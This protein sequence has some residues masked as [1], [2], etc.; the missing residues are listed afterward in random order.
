MT[1][2]ME[3]AFVRTAGGGLARVRGAKT[4]A[5]CRSSVS[6]VRVSMTR[7]QVR[8][9]AKIA[10]M[11]EKVP[12]EQRHAVLALSEE[13]DMVDPLER[14][15]KVVCT[16][17]PST[18]S[19]QDLLRLA[20][21]GM[22]LVRLNMSHGDYKFHK[23]VLDNVRKINR[24]S[25]F[26]VGT[27]VDLGSLDMV[28]LGE[29]ADAP[30]LDKGDVFTLTVRHEAEYDQ[31]TSEVSYD[32][33][34]DVA[35]TGD[36]VMIDDS[37]EL[38]VTSKTNT[39]V[40]CETT[41]GGEVKSRAPLTVRGKS[42]GA[43]TGD[44]LESD[45]EF[46]VEEDVDYV[47]LAFV[48]DGAVVDKLRSELRSRG[49]EAAIIAKMESAAAL[50]NA[51]NIIQAA[52]AIMVARGDLGA[53]IPYE[54][55]PLW[56]ERLA[57]LSRALGKPVLISTHFLDSMVTYP[58]PTRAEITDIFE[59]VRQKAD[60]LVL[61][62]ET[63]SGRYPFKALNAMHSASCRM[64]GKSQEETEID[65]LPPLVTV[66]DRPFR[67][68]AVVAENISNTAS[69]LA[70]VR[71]AKAIMV[72]THKGLMASLVSRNRPNAPILAFTPVNKVREKMTLLHGVQP[73]KL[74]FSDDP[75]DTIAGAFDILS[76]RKSVNSGDLVVIVADVL[77]GQSGAPEAEKRAAFDEFSDGSGSIPNVR[78]RA[79]LRRMSLKAPDAAET[80]LSRAGGRMEFEEFSQLADRAKQI[81][82][83][84]QRDIVHDERRSVAVAVSPWFTLSA[85]VLNFQRGGAPTSWRKEDNARYDA[86]MEGGG[87]LD[88][89]N[90]VLPRLL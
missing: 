69:I 33:F 24:E 44:V 62:A 56:Q 89:Q 35:D 14:R 85:Q 3:P 1:A 7:E 67:S 40:V 55:V 8:M 4:T 13:A 25:P 49:S 47:S 45:L 64:E 37:I 19:Y 38:L 68:V 15:T 28:R 83:T 84:V 51:E 46:A 71:F 81:V 39:D 5:Q 42:Y 27:I 18:N 2:A 43:R 59:A 32:G 60:A 82:H 66:N 34:I 21:E 77:G 73:F 86:R 58:T 12:I 76:Q 72:F 50:K 78:V 41:K 57:A 54:K 74:D 17:G 23:E 52:D 31:F 61:T 26:L 30:K 29:F 80:R 90:T 6:R 53:S 20:A 22:N 48:E 87:P 75:E 65:Q 79:A 88:S 11:L 16:I 36:L 70:N 9:A 10:D 63:A